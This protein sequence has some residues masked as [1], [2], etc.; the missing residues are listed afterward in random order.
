MSSTIEELIERI[1]L[2]RRADIG[3]NADARIKLILAAQA[4]VSRIET[5]NE[6]I[7]R[8]TFQEVRRNLLP[9]VP[10]LQT[11]VQGGYCKAWVRREL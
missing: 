4:L 1:N 8:V 7:Q 3:D 9:Y 11:P 10:A 2:T 5:P 6:F